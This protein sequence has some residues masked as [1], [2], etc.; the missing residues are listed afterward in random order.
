MSKRADSTNPGQ[1][2]IRLRI[3]YDGPRLEV[4]SRRRVRMRVTP[5]DDLPRPRKGGGVTGWWVELRDARENTLYRRILH[6]PIPYDVE[7]RT[8]LRREPLARHRVDRPKGNLFLV[9]PDLPGAAVVVLFGPTEKDGGTGE[10]GRFPVTPDE[11]V[12]V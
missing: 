8:G 1:A 9:V 4:H 10:V 2:A 3:A 7:V 11:P 5:S 12:V 6:N